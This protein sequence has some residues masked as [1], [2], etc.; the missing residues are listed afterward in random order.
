MYI[1]RSQF[2]SLVDVKATR[3]AGLTS[4]SVLT[5][6]TRWMPVPQKICIYS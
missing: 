5:A 3:T 6:V 4:T 1:V 2:P